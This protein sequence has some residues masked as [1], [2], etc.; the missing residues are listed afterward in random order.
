M[1]R[2]PDGATR[3]EDDHAGLLGQFCV[4]EPGRHRADLAFERQPV[5]TIEV[6]VAASCAQIQEVPFWHQEACGKPVGLPLDSGLHGRE[7]F[8]RVVDP[9]GDDQGLVVCQA[10][11]TFE[12]VNRCERTS[13]EQ[14]ARLME[15][16]EYHA[17][18][19]DIPRRPLFLTMLI[20]HVRATLLLRWAEAKILR[21]VQSG[22]I[23]IV[24]S[25]EAPDTT[26]EI[27]MA[28]MGLAAAAMTSIEDGRL[29]IMPDCPLEPLLSKDPRIARLTD[30]AGLFLNSL[31]LPLPRRSKL[32]P[33]RIRFAH[34]AFQEFSLAANIARNFDAFRS[35]ALPAEI[36]AWIAAIEEEKLLG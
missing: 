4:S 22:R 34:R 29:L 13:L 21:D 14:I 36:D 9:A 25:P 24:E 16:G 11:T 17:H 33:R 12:V 3:R 5:E 23:G 18:Y 15:S 1:K 35:T 20:E 27:A 8:N 31:L 6:E 10:H 30:P 28:A 19:G 26:T 32:Q 7:G 2:V